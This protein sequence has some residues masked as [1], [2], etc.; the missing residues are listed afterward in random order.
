MPNANELYFSNT[1]RSINYMTLLYNIF[2][3]H[4]LCYEKTLA[5]ISEPLN[6]RSKAG[7]N[8]SYSAQ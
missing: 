5:I 7:Y 2:N 6:I 8:K 1:M 3:F 4:A